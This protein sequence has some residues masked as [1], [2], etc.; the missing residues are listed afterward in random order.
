VNKSI[1]QN[2]LPKKHENHR[3]EFQDLKKMMNLLELSEKEENAARK[4]MESK[5][6]E[7]E[8]A[9][10][11]F[12]EKEGAREKSRSI[13]A[14]SLTN[15]GLFIEEYKDKT[16][17][18]KLQK[19][20]ILMGKHD[21]TIKE[22]E[23]SKKKMDENKKA[24]DKATAEYLKKKEKREQVR[25]ELSSSFI[26]TAK[27]LIKT[28]E[29]EENNVDNCNVCFEKYD[30]IDRHSCA[31]KCGHLTCQKCLNELPEKLCPICREPFVEDNVI[32][33]FLS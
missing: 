15:V 5:E 14:T 3:S 11:V 9:K 17:A 7:F 24:L 2:G 30:K 1:L 33:V 21:T 20:R 31:P 16:E 6:K 25:N 28:E 26:D 4:I 8:L 29:V 22:E 10:T 13:L 23:V 19:L 12:N 18:S 32:K 27:D